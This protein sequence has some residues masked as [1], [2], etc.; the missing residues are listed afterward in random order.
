MVY[1]GVLRAQNVMDHAVAP[2]PA[3]VRG[4]D[5][6]A[7]QVHIERTGLAHMAVAVSA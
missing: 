2:A 4:L 1:V 3:G 7:A 5:D 6:A